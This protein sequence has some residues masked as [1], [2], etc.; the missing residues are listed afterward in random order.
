[1]QPGLDGLGAKTK[2]N[3]GL[4]D[5]H[6]LEHAS[7]QHGPKSLRQLVNCSFQ[8]ELDFALSHCAFGIELWGRMKGSD[9][10]TLRL[11]PGL[12]RGQI[13]RLATAATSAERL[14]QHDAR[15]PCR[16]A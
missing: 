2:E 8:H 10:L 1:M 6:L 4:H 14:I 11:L 15:E 3:C 7:N 16:E 13:D 12:D 5:A 9:D